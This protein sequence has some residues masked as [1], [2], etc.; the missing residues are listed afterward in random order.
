[1]YWDGC[2]F[3][4]IFSVLFSIKFKA[5]W[6][7]TGR[8]WPSRFCFQ[9]GSFPTTKGLEDSARNCTPGTGEID[10]LAG[11]AKQLRLNAHFINSRPEHP[12]P[13][14]SFLFDSGFPFK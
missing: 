12:P 3:H 9:R 4:N 8:S 7:C 10:T 2:L 6:I 14:I 13:W 1:M 5:L 11:R